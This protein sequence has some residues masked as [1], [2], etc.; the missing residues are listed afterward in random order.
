V[1]SAIAI[2]QGLYPD[3]FGPSGWLPG[4]PQYVPVFSD[5]DE[6]E[7]LIDDSK[8]WA[9]SVADQ[10]RWYKNHFEE[11]MSD[12]ITAAAI[13]EVIELCGATRPTDNG[14]MAIFVKIVVDGIIFNSDYG[15]TVLNGKV[16]PKLMAELRNI[17]IRFLLGR[18]ETTEEQKTYM[19]MDFPHQLLLMASQRTDVTRFNSF[20]HPLQKFQ[21][22][23]GHRE[24][25]YGLAEFF[26]M[27]VNVKGL[28]PSELPV[29]ATYIFDIYRQWNP[30]RGVNVTFV[31]TSLWTLNAGEYSMAIPGCESPRLCTSEDL[32]RIIA[33]RE[34]RTG[35]WWDICGVKRDEE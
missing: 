4:R 3:G 33:K 22:Y 6:H 27:T 29:A 34:S 26:G 1:Q 8:C 19:P 30:T 35:S 11:Y 32:A 10:K 25:L 21:V 24:E 28:A 7:D 5:L 13:N 16:T 9:N 17:S 15:L 14:K 12:P 23:V 31:K 2:G 20:L 18:L